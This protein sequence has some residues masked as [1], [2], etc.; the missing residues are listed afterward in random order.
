MQFTRADALRLFGLYTLSYI[1]ITALA[2]AATR[3][4]QLDVRTDVIQTGLL[5]IAILLLIA[6]HRVLVPSLRREL[7]HANW[8]WHVVLGLIFVAM[9]LGLVGFGAFLFSLPGAPLADWWNTRAETDIAA[10]LATLNQPIFSA[11]VLYH[12]IA[13]WLAATGLLLIANWPI[14]NLLSR[15]SG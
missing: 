11:G 14:G 15:L 12:H 4:W 3:T 13:L 1:A 5:A 2:I 9:C 10:V 7:T 6:Q 8:W